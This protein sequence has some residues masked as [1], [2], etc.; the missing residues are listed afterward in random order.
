MEGGHAL[1]E[2]GAP[3]STRFEPRRIAAEVIALL[4][5]ELAQ[6]GFNLLDVRVFRGG[7]RIILRIFLDTAEGGITMDEVATASRTAS[8]LLEEADRISDAYVLE[9][10]SPGVRRPLR[11]REHYLAVVGQ[12]IEVKVAVT[13]GSK[14]LRGTLL[15]VG[16]TSVTI[17]PVP[18]SENAPAPSEGEAKPAAAPTAP[19]SEAKPVTIGFNRLREGN[20]DPEFDVQA[21]IHADRRQKKDAKQQARRERPARRKGRPKNRDGAKPADGKDK[22][23]S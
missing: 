15:E 9:V 11:T 19:A 17:R 13:D 1:A 16:T 2:P 5:G 14:R 10:S 22:Q 20:L 7:G 18:R 8:M 23:E 4:E 3:E 21:I 12:R 6:Q